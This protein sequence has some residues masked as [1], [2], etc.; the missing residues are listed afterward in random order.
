MTWARAK[1]TDES[2]LTIDG[3]FGQMYKR[4]RVQ[5]RKKEG[6]KELIKLWENRSDR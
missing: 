3:L 4:H 1:V 6:R 5:G 2:R